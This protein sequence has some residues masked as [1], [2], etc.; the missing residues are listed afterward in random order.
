VLRVLVG[1]RGRGG[2]GVISEYF[3]CGF[4]LDLAYC[5]LGDLAD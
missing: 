2:E 4:S 5:D 1:L 3:C